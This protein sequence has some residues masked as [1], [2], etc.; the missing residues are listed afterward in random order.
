[1]KELAE[2]SCC[3]IELHEILLRIGMPPNLYGYSYIVYSMELILQNPEYLHSITK[4]LYIDVAKQFNT[5]PSRVERAI[6]H[7]ISATW[8]YGNT[9]YI[10][11]IF[12][13]CVRSDKRTPTNSLFLARLFYYMQ[14][15]REYE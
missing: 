7:A 9:D 8:L 2:P 1:M 14:I 3:T 13:N 6:R 11:K 10:H 15:V 4:R 5:T 12:K